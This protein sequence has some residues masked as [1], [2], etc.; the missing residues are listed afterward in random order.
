MK[1]DWIADLGKARRDLGFETLFTLEQGLGETIAWYLLEG[2]AVS[3]PP[4]PGLHFSGTFL[5][6]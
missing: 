1:Q 3:G 6:N 4:R 5:Y 2:L